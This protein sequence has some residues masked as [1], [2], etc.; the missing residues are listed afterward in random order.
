MPGKSKRKILIGQLEELALL[1]EICPDSSS[2]SSYNSSSSDAGS[3]SGDDLGSDTDDEDDFF[4]SPLYLLSVFKSIRYL[5]RSYVPKSRDF[6]EKILP[7]LTEERF[8]SEIRISRNGFQEILRNIKNHPV[9]TNNAFNK[10]LSI[11][12]QLS[13][14]LYRFGRYGNGA[15][16]RDIA[17]HFGL[18]E[19]TLNLCTN[20][21]I[22]A[23]IDLAPRYL[24]WYSPS[25]K[26]NTKQQI[27]LAKDFQHCLGFLDGTTI[28]LD[29]KPGI[30]SEAYY[31]R[32][33]RYGLNTQV[34]C[35]WSGRIRFLFV[36]Y[37]ASVHD[38]RCIGYS[39]LTTNPHQYFDDM[40][41]ILA[42]SAYT[43]SN[44]IITPFKHPLASTEPYATF[45]YLHSSARVHV[46]HCI[47]RLKSRFQS[48]RGL[49]IQILDHD[50]HKRACQWIVA[51]CII[52]N[53]LIDI[54]GWDNETT[55]EPNNEDIPPE[56]TLSVDG[57]AVAK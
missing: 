4:T 51:C 23:I 42:D 29:F 1:D 12:D 47:G 53:M 16:T 24:Q 38:S 39:N 10:Q 50:D 8:K 2:D 57:T 18:G 6:M 44:T 46:E 40:E 15:S 22:E 32:K 19:G 34:V 49:R 31:N 28:I 21:V 45:N 5:D 20:R 41:Y 25:E 52:H 55:N 43:L 36:G 37:P 27:K 33:S 35:D 3:S 17:S 26:E 9:F 13:I 54:D 48:L 7:I 56:T 11:Y 30:D 14:T